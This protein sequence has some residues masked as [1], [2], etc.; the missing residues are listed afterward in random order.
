M[1]ERL[2]SQV[3]AQ[4]FA[5]GKLCSVDAELTR[6]YARDAR[7]AEV[8]A[9]LA[10]LKEDRLAERVA[11]GGVVAEWRQA[12]A[13]L[14]ETRRR[15]EAAVQEIVD[16]A[17]AISER[18]Y[19]RFRGVSVEIVDGWIERLHALAGEIERGAATAPTGAAGSEGETNG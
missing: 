8:E 3:L 16:V 4:R 13:E 11:A 15:L 12:T 10:D 5:A 6:L 9:E 14:A 1:G 18:F 7:C 19:P 2:T 17:F